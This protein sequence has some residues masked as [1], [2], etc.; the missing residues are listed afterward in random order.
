ME[1]KSEQQRRTYRC[2]LNGLRGLGYGN[3]LL[4][5]EYS[6]SDFFEP[7]QPTRV[8]PAAAFGRT[9]PS[10]DTA[11]MS[12]LLASS[13][14]S[15]DLVNA[16]RGLGAPVALEVD[17]DVVRQWKVSPESSASQ[18]WREFPASDIQSAFRQNSDDWSPDSILRAKNITA[19]LQ[20]RQ[21][22]FVD[23]GLLPALE[24]QVRAK[25]DALLR[26][27]LTSA[28]A[29]HKRQ[30]RRRANV[31]EL[32]RLV[33]R[34]LAAKVLCDRHVNGFRSIKNFENVDDVLARVGRYYKRP[35]PIINDSETR[36][37]V[38]NRLW[39]S[40]SFQNLSVESLAYV[41][42]HTLI[43]DKTR[44][45][46]GIHST[47]LS[48]A[49]FIAD[50]MLTSA[51]IDRPLRIVEP[52]SGH[53]IFLVAALERLRDLLPADVD[54]EI[55]HRYFIRSLYGF[56]KDAFALEISRLCLMLA[57]FPFPN[58]WHLKSADAFDSKPFEK[59]VS[60]ADVVL[61][62]P[63]FESF[64]E[65]E[66][67]AY[68]DLTST[69]KPV[70][71]LNR[72]LKELRPTSTLGF[73]LPRQVLDGK[74]YKSIRE[75]LAR[76]FADI[77]IVALPDRVFN[78]SQLETAIL[79]AKSPREDVSRITVSYSHVREADRDRFMSD[80]AVSWRDC[81]RK[82]KEAAT[83][84]LKV[85]P[86]RDVW[87]FFQEQ[88]QPTIQTIATLHRGVEWQPP[89]VEE[90]YI[91]RTEKRSYRK[92]FYRV[93]DTSFSFQQPETMYLSF[94]RAD[95]RRN[96]F[97]LPWE[98]SKVFVN[99]ARLS[100]GPW[101]LAA[102]ADEAQ[103][104]SSRR[105]FALWPKKAVGVGVI[106]A[107]LNGPVANAFVTCREHNQ[108]NRRKTVQQIPIP[109]LTVS[110]AQSLT[111]AV[112]EYQS[113]WDSDSFALQSNEFPAMAKR[114][115]LEIDAILLRAYNLPP[116][117]ERQLLDFF[118]G[119]SRRVPFPF[120]EYF[121]ANF[122]PNIPLWMYLSNDFGN[123]NSRF[124]LENIPAI[125]DPALMDALTEVE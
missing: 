111:R 24:E 87:D 108:D 15:S 102:F 100:R 14:D 36:S 47:P 60:R 97:D 46:L 88:T 120:T 63:P 101:R 22:D 35:E 125:D 33:F 114:A 40:V 79:L 48:I 4:I 73:V 59:A 42:E 41:Y 117:L 7:D 18:I 28:I 19:R 32:F 6:F 27:V 13:S 92:G 103:H 44:K 84:S 109:K 74:S 72:V 76:R 70:E 122:G 39:N 43:D 23:L 119:F 1:F 51:D 54:P 37:A 82:S 61:C 17:D 112:C 3:G 85:S 57:D 77:E 115:L 67:D 25:L 52:C 83:E 118:R 38:A 94:R 11:C 65:K 64:K 113:L 78:I 53:G 12:V 45:K 90:K 2:V 123:C 16:H 10:F 75:Q 34:L 121:P 71:L 62:N 99:T 58:G 56:E 116:R 124:L 31:Q 69:L 30:T 29:T 95:R 89:F 107:I 50:R 9:P 81:E 110:Q 106:A 68:S 26:D 98:E 20:S 21:L 49:R 93:D 5:E 96:A 55:R 91:S 66:R 104:C 86:L 105:F 8:L 80:Y